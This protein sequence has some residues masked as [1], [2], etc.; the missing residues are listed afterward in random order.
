MLASPHWQAIAAEP[1]ADRTAFTEIN[2]RLRESGERFG[3]VWPTKRHPLTYWADGLRLYKQR[4]EYAQ[5]PPS[6][7]RA[8]AARSGRAATL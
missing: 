7:P 4:R 5:N 2:R 1:F 3:N 8:A 6:W